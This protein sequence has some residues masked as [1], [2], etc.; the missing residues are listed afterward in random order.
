MMQWAENKFQQ[1][2]AKTELIDLGIQTLPSGKELLLPP[3]L[4]GSIG[5]DPKKK[6]VLIYGHLDVQPALKEDGWNTEPFDLVEKD[7]KLYGRGSTDDKG[8]VL[9]WLHALEGFLAIGEN[10]PVNLKVSG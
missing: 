2:G 8:P 3:A 1:V 7:G 4:L 10:I 6:T 5:N 9:C